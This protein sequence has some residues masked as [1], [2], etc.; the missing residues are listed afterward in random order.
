VLLELSTRVVY[1]S[2]VQCLLEYGTCQ[3]SALPGGLPH[4]L[5]CSETARESSQ[6]KGVT[7][8][9]LPAPCHMTVNEATAAAATTSLGTT[10]PFCSP[11]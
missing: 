10:Q 5:L 8:W 9:Q 1:S 4:G 3:V 11:G 6:A 7:Q 2:S